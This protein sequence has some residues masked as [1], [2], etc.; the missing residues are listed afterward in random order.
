MNTLQKFIIPLGNCKYFSTKMKTR[1]AVAK[2][3]SLTSSGKVKRGMA[4]KR[5]ILTKKSAARKNRIGGVATITG[6]IKKNLLK[7]LQG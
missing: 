5:H 4:N 3:I 1:K 7:M 6:K 2:R